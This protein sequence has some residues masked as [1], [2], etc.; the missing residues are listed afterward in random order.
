MRKSIGMVETRSL[1]GAIQ[2]A[3]AMT[4]SA[5]VKIINFTVVGSGIVSVIVEGDVAAVQSAVENG[6]LEAGKISEI[7][8]YN[9]IPSPNS[10]VDKMIL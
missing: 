1:V 2:A 6:V 4:K 3:D 9:V 8:S 10:E 7:I 5:D